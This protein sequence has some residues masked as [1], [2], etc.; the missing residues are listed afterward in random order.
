MVSDPGTELDA[1]KKKKKD[2]VRSA[3]ISF[4][5]RILAQMLGAAASIGLGLMVLQSY[6]TS[7]D[8]SGTTPTK[9]VAP[10][11]VSTPR[12]P[13]VVSLA[14]L[15]LENFSGNPRHD[16]F[17][18]AMSEA[19]IASLAQRDNLRVISRTSSMQYKGQL[20]SLPTVAQELGVDVIIEGSLV[21]AGDRI[22]VTAQLIEGKSDE[23][24]WARS[25]DQR[26][27]D[28][29]AVQGDVAEAIAR[30][31]AAVLTARAAAPVPAGGRLLGL[32]EP[33]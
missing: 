28:V 3:W 30:E 7:S 16:A 4:F 24:L 31:V 18:D 19:L 14:V 13:G 22:R 15:P 27:R 33:E 12:G 9:D 25:Y 1:R 5:G 2:K 26:I 11:R 6:K 29:M 8:P 10:A 21:T 32:D 20:K 23:H 17:A